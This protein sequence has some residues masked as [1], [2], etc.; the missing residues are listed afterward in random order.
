MTFKSIAARRENGHIRLLPV[1]HCLLQLPDE[2]IGEL[3]FA[4]AVCDPEKQI[5]ITRSSDH[6]IDD[7]DLSSSESLPFAV[8]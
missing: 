8:S 7:S 5:A 2:P 1:F 6:R 4:A 3:S